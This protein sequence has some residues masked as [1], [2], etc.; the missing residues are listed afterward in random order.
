[1]LWGRDPT[2]TLHAVD[3]TDA[4]LSVSR[5]YNETLCGQINLTTQVEFEPSPSGAICIACTIGATADLHDPGRFGTAQQ[6]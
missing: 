3:R 5:G 2:G 1:V 6:R 4:L